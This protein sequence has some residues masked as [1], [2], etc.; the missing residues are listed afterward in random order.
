MSNIEKISCCESYSPVGLSYCS[1]SHRFFIELE[2]YNTGELKI[3]HKAKRKYSLNELLKHTV[4]MPIRSGA[5][6]QNGMTN[7][8]K[9]QIK[10]ASRIFQWQVLEGQTQKAY[11]SFITLTYGE[12]YPDDHTSKKHLD[13]FIKRLK[14]KYPQF[15]YVWVIEKQKR[16]APH[17][18]ILTPNY[19]SKEIINKSWNGVVSKWQKS[20][21]NNGCKQQEVY[22]HVGKVLEAGKYMTKYMQK[23]GENIGGNMYGIDFTTRNLMKP[24]TITLEGQEDLNDISQELSLLITHKEGISYECTDFNGNHRGWVSK[25]NQLYLREFLEYSVN[26]LNL[27]KHGEYQYH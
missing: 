25:V 24:N 22:P 8:A 27:N 15:Q 20:E 18:H 4:S 2:S 7:H 6:Y 19:I 5:I 21:V 9:K 11:A 26:E 14:R 12:H 13:N 23:E 17:F 3:K 1:Q 16:G 10:L